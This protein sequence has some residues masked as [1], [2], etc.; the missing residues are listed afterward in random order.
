MINIWQQFDKQNCNL[1]H[2]IHNQFDDYISFELFWAPLYRHPTNCKLHRDFCSNILINT[3]FNLN[4]YISTLTTANYAMQNPDHSIKNQYAQHHSNIH[5][6]SQTIEQQYRTPTTQTFAKACQQN[7]SQWIK[8]QW[9][10]C[11]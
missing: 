3:I 11:F 10:A 4:H 1:C 6:P 9:I 5:K 7:W 8:V 2:V